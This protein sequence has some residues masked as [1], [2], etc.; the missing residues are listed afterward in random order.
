V[1]LQVP[2]PLQVDTRVEFQL[3]LAPK[4]KGTTGEVACKG[5]VV[6]VITGDEAP[7]PGFAIAIEQYDIRPKSRSAQQGR[8]QNQSQLS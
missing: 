7:Q 2:D 6:R 8:F 5:R 4:G 1:L 3:A